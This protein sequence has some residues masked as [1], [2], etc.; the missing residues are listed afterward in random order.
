MIQ[1]SSRNGGRSETGREDRAGHPLTGTQL[2]VAALRAGIRI[3]RYVPGQRLVEADLATEIGVGRNSLREAFAYLASEGLLRV[4]PY[5]GASIRR[6]TRDEVAE[7]YDLSEVL[8]GLAARLAAVNITEPG[9]AE[10]LSAAIER[11]Q[12]GASGG[13]AGRRIDDAAGL[14]EAILVI[15]GRPR[16]T[17]LVTNLHILTFS[18][19]L[20]HAQLAGSEGLGET[21]LA[22]HVAVV[23]AIRRADPPQAEAA[24]RAHVRGTR[25]RVLALPPTAFD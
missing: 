9:H 21:A 15:A 17:E 22:D 8:E 14:H 20:R 7:L 1:E 16:L 4:E 11:E 3:G 18:F 12:E 19:Q 25:E 10:S 5:R 2:A 23:E 13:S 24:M 6:R